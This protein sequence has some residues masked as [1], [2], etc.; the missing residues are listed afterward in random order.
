MKSF[1]K[2]PVESAAQLGPMV[3]T[4]L[5]LPKHEQLLSG[6]PSLSSAWFLANAMQNIPFQT[7]MELFYDA[8]VLANT[9]EKIVDADEQLDT[10][11]RALYLMN[12]SKTDEFLQSQVDTCIES[13]SS[14]ESWASAPPDV[15][16]FTTSSIQSLLPPVG[17]R[18]RQDIWTWPLP[19]FDLQ[20]FDETVLTQRFPVFACTRRSFQDV[21]Q[22]KSLHSKSLPEYDL[23][24]PRTASEI[25]GSIHDSLW[26]VFFSSGNPAPIFR[27]I[28]M[29]ACSFQKYCSLFEG[30]VSAKPQTTTPV[31]SYVSLLH[32]NQAND[33]RAIVTQLPTKNLAIVIYVMSGLSASWSLL[34]NARSH[35]KVK[36]ILSES[37]RKLQARAGELSPEE[38]RALSVLQVL[39]GLLEH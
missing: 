30:N 31:Q 15:V 17:E 24:L 11:L 38:A 35:E 26:S 3:T 39:E 10:L 5:Q 32:T 25:S 19:S 13:L 27:L 23:A 28:D 29:A 14:F 20:V 12:D 2:S 4:M 1:Y 36:T 6:P 22:L 37:A 33:I 16:E 34:E 8:S 21:H 18:A 9:S 7:R